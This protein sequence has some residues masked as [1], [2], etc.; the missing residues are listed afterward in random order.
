[1]S[2]VRCAPG[3]PDFYIGA[4]GALFKLPMPDEY[5]TNT[6]DN[7]TVNHSLLG[8]GNAVQHGSKIRR[9]YGLTW[10]A[11]LAEDA[12]V[13]VAIQAGMLGPGPYY[14]IDPLW[15][16]VLPAHISSAGRKK[17]D[18]AGFNPTV[19]SVAYSSAIAPPALNP[20]TIPPGVQV[21]TG[22]TTGSQLY[23]GATTGG[24][25]SAD[26][27]PALP[28]VDPFSLPMTFAFWGKVATGT[29]TL[30]LAAV[31]NT[32]GF[33]SPVYSP[34]TATCALTTTWQRF[35]L[36]LTAAQLDATAAF[37]GMRLTCTTASAP[38][39][40]LSALGAQYVNAAPSALLSGLPP[41][42]L[43]LPV[44]RVLVAAAVPANHNRGNYRRSH[45]LDLVEAA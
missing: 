29:A 14:F 9:H 27:P 44:P 6:L 28:S 24:I 35:A 7:N 10:T 22:A 37:A 20:L 1:M 13:I 31:Q 26:M 42:V 5:Y 12:D 38:A 40:H 33:A 16:N 19:G 15:R 43:G 4:A 18:S 2:S 39:V 34:T 17:Q 3:N 36:P 32:A 45:A 8:G 11:R 41:W 21:W 23:I 25:L 30:T